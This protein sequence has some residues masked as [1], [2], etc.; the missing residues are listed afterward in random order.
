AQETV[1]R[2]C[3]MLQNMGSAGWAAFP[4][5]T[6]L[7][8]KAD[9]Q[10]SGSQTPQCDMLDRADKQCDLLVLGQTLTTDTGGMGAGGG[11]HALGQVHADVRSG[12]IDAAAKFTA[13]ILEQQLIPAI[14]RL[15]YG[16]CEEAPNLHLQPITASAPCYKT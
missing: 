8:L 2:I 3:A 9:G 5:G 10:K 14:L 7:E 12:I 13:G 4:A 11:S 1:D 15:N 16:D 6:S